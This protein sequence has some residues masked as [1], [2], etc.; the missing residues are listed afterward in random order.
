MIPMVM[1]Q[2][3]GDISTQ[4]KVFERL[5]TI[6]DQGRGSS[7]ARDETRGSCGVH[8]WRPHTTPREAKAEVGRRNSQEKKG[9]RLGGE[10]PMDEGGPGGWDGY[11]MLGTRVFVFR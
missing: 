8:G 5:E 4:P 1:R 2:K 3:P 10:S 9:E 7:D 11:E 6:D